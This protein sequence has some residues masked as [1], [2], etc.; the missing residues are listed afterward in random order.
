MRAQTSPHILKRQQQ[1][2]NSF[3]TEALIAKQSDNW[4]SRKIDA[5]LFNRILMVT[6]F[7]S[8]T[9]YPAVI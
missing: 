6:D 7:K 9:L 1:S 4:M 3:P 5:A 2:T 8:Q